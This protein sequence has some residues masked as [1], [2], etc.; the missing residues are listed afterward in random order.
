[1]LRRLFTIASAVS[2]VLCVATCVLWVRSYSRYEGV[3][4]YPSARGDG[5]MLCAYRG[6]LYASVVPEAGAGDLWFAATSDPYEPGQSFAFDRGRD[7]LGL[8]W[9]LWPDHPL[10]V[11][12]AGVPFWAVALAA[13]A[14]PGRRLAARW[15]GRGERR[16]ARAGRCPACGYDLRATPDRCPEC[17]A[18]AQASSPP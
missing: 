12:F 4:A 17:G 15:R 1:M 16:R 6:R 10:S 11:R 9:R 13:A 14:P 5:Y 3:A 8:R 18:E 2:L 7:A